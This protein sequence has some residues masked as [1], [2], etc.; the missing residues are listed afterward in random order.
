MRGQA[1]IV[2]FVLL[3]LLSLTL[4][5]SAVSWGR[6]MSQQH[7][8]VGRLTAAESFMKGLDATIQS[9]GRNGGSA[10][11]DYPLAAP[12]RLS[13]I[14]LNDTIEVSFPIT[15]TT[16]EYWVN[17]TQPGVSVIRERME[18]NVFRLQLSYPAPASGFAY[19]LFTD[20]PQTATPGAVLVERN[21]TRTQA[22][23][24]IAVIRL[25]FE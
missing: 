2:V 9:V 7:L 6:T 12:I 14:G 16:P 11:L 13:D 19:D 10:R 5:L 18:G 25:T 23:L 17:L 21:T 24:T 3:L 4:V 22:G 1:Q 15:T 8:D 20:G